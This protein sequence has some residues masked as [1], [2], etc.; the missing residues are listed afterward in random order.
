MLLDA[1]ALLVLLQDEPGAEIVT[2][3]MSDA[4]M[5]AAN[6]SEVVAKLIQHGVPDGEAEAILKSF[7]L[8]IVPVDE[9]I[10][11]MA[12]KLIKQ[13]RAHGLSLGDRICIASGILRRD[14]LLTA[15]KVW[16]KISIEGVEIKLIR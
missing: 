15:D 11:V 3:A 4:S 2:D 16:S 7:D 5:S 8:D 14:T 10:A 12:G 6:L 13:T 1:S 9:E